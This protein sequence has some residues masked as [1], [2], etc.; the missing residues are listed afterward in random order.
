MIE[1]CGKSIT[2]PLNLIFQSVLNNGLSPDDIVPCH[3]KD[4]KNLIKHYRPISLLP[5]FCKAFER[6]IYNSLYNYF[7]QNK[8]FTEWHSGFMPG[9]SCA[10]QVL[11]TTHEIYYSFDYNPAVDIRGVFLDI[12][13]AFDKAW[14]DGLIFKLQTCGID[15]KLSKLLKSYLKD[16]Q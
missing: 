1:V 14:N 9:D 15:D 8:L 11:S 6:L 3:K 4:S 2:R 16:R 13:K 12:S 10:A 5:I 7:I